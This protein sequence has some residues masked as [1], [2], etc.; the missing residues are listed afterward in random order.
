MN[1]SFLRIKKAVAAFALGSLLATFAATPIALA[2]NHPDWARGDDMGVGATQANRCEA[3]AI[4]LLNAGYE[5]TEADAEAASNFEDI[6]GQCLQDVGLGVQLGAINAEGKTEYNGDA[7]VQRTEYVLMITRLLQDEMDARIAAGEEVADL[8]EAHTAELAA[9]THSSWDTKVFTTDADGNSVELD[10]FQVWA[11]SI[12]FD[13]IKGENNGEFLNPEGALNGFQAAT[14]ADRAAE[15]F[16]LTAEYSSSS[17][18]ESMDEEP[19]SEE[20]ATPEV[21][22]EGGDLMVTLSDNSP[23]SASIPNK[24][25][26][27]EVA[28]Y[29]LRS[30]SEDTNVSSITVKRGGFGDDDTISRVALFDS[31]GNRISR[32]T[33]LNSDD[34]ATLNLLG[35]GMTVDSGDS[36]D[37]VLVASIGNNASAG[38]EFNFYVYSVESNAS[39]TDIGETV[40]STHE[41]K[42]VEANSLV[43]NADGMPAD[44]KVGEAD[45]EIVKFELSAGANVD[46][47]ENGAAND[48]VT[49]DSDVF[50]NG[51]TLRQ[52]GTID[53]DQ[54]SN[55][56]LYVDNEMVAEADSMVNDYLTF[57]LET[58]YLI[59]DGESESA[60]VTADILGGPGKTIYFQIDDE[61][62]IRATDSTYGVGAQTEDLDFDAGNVGNTSSTRVDVLAGE[63][64]IIKRDVENDEFT[65]NIENFELGSI[66]IVSGSGKQL[67]L[68]KIALSLQ[69]TQSTNNVTLDN[70][71]KTGTFE[72]VVKRNGASAGTYSLTE[73]NLNSRAA[74]LSDTSLNIKLPET[75]TT[76]LTFRGDLQETIANIANVTLKTQI[77][78]IGNADSSV[79]GLYIK[80]DDDNNPVTDITP[81]SITF[82]D[83][84]G[85]DASIALTA[86]NISSTKNVVVGSTGVV[87]G[88]FNVEATDASYADVDRLV[89]DA[90][91]DVTDNVGQELQTVTITTAGAA[92]NGDVGFEVGSDKCVIAQAD[93][94]TATLD[95]AGATNLIALINNANNASCANF[96]A[97]ETSTAG[98]AAFTLSYSGN[99]EAATYTVNRDADGNAANNAFEATVNDATTADTV[100]DKSRVSTAYLYIDSYNPEEPMTNLIAEENASSFSNGVIDFNDFDSN[101]EHVTGGEVRI[102]AGEDRDFILV[103]DIE[104]DEDQ[105]N[106][107]LKVN[108]DAVYADDQESDSINVTA[109]KAVA[110]EGQAVRTIKLRGNASLAVSIDK[111]DRDANQS[112]LVVGGNAS[113]YIASFELIA[114]N[115]DI[116]LEDIV[117]SEEGT[118]TL[119]SHVSKLQLWEKGAETFLAEEDVTS[120]TVTFSNVNYTAEEG[121]SNLYLKAVAR[122]IGADLSGANTTSDLTFAMSVSP[123]DTDITPT[124]DGTAKTLPSYGLAVVSVG[125]KE[126]AFIDSVSTEALG[127]VNSATELTTGTNT[128]GF[129]SVTADLNNNTSSTNSAEELETRLEEVV[130]ALNG[131]A[132]INSVELKSMSGA[133]SVSSSTV[134]GYSVKSGQT[135]KIQNPDN[136]AVD[137]TFYKNGAWMKFAFA[138]TDDEAAGDAG[139]TAAIVCL[140]RA[141]RDG[142]VA[143]ANAGNLAVTTSAGAEDANGATKNL[144]GSDTLSAITTAAENTDNQIQWA[145]NNNDANDAGVLV[146]SIG[147]SLRV[148]SSLGAAGVLATSGV[149]ATG[150]DLSLVNYALN[151]SSMSSDRVLEEGESVNYELV[152]DVNVDAANSQTTEI[153]LPSIDNAHIK[154]GDGTNSYTVLRK[155]REELKGKK[156]VERV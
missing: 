41:V 80:E 64:S 61:L 144:L 46:A 59:E 143:C 85:V 116:E 24:A 52:Q 119:K 152:V 129:L 88:E 56:K 123:T 74:T 36:L 133:E 134:D 27:V 2:D 54:V 51:I 87:A 44:V 127:T 124:Y 28:A 121:S 25:A 145:G 47:D 93:I 40:S 71:F 13:L 125:I 139:V 1:T 23:E 140:D 57:D 146:M 98:D 117:I 66:E 78:N 120:D 67:I 110:G 70:V 37:V 17:S 9:S 5:S 136:Q 99:Q 109:K 128:I 49:S 101:S 21:E 63:L 151:V 148:K 8:S 126:L 22:A 45:V 69:N 19:D 31:E 142:G 149:Y 83:L 39:S 11:R 100:L 97:A 35:G 34:E 12:H 118:S 6:E 58:P 91:A 29:T 48:A 106:D 15:S 60:Y 55:F 156:L 154:Y 92:A 65:R 113:D 115:G 114:T 95:A 75:G 62:D 108:L 138:A 105:S 32:S 10:M 111:A 50:F 3:L 102:E 122:G 20:E 79:S 33:T 147:S 82:Q 137:Y 68:E 7:L 81:G 150:S 155:V 103:L 53:E 89:F 86:V 104:N 38:D 141:M 77:A 135:L 130:V 18:E 131:S 73:A 30:S 16:E 14:V 26:N 90:S 107:T 42:S 96:T 153:S 72:V 43:V 132:T 94:A 84:R 4:A 112:R 76:V